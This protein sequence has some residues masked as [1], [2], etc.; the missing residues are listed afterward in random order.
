M[1][2]LRQLSSRPRIGH[3]SGRYDGDLEDPQDSTRGRARRRAG[4]FVQCLGSLKGARQ[5]QL[6]VLIHGRKL[7]EEKSRSGEGNDGHLGC[8][9]R[10]GHAEQGCKSMGFGRATT[11]CQDTETL[12]THLALLGYLQDCECS[13]EILADVA[14]YVPTSCMS[15]I[16][17]PARSDRS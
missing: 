5:C 17:I 13:Y 7:E 10:Q 11:D 16:H 4:N 12:L 8:G 9:W 15:E 6:Y 3:H 1:R 2:Q 14:A